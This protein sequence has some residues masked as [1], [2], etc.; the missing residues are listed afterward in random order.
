MLVPSTERNFP[1][2]PDKKQEHFIPKNRF[3]ELWRGISY[4]VKHGTSTIYI[5]T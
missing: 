4:S 2:K 5:V 1:T 3:Q